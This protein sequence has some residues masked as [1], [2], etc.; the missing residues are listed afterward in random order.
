MAEL[1]AV[2]KTLQALEKAYIK[3]CVTPNE[4]VAC[5]YAKWLDILCL[6]FKM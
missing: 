4:L 2:V 6:F 5:F 1:F 3:D